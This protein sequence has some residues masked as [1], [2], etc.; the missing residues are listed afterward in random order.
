MTEKEKQDELNDLGYNP[1][2]QKAIGN[3]AIE[4]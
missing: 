2:E 1:V 3:E 4:D